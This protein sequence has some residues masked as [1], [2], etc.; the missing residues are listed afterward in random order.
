ML[1]PVA[2]SALSIHPTPA[3]PGQPGTHTRAPSPPPAPPPGAP[4]GQMP[5]SGGGGGASPR[6]LP[7][8]S[9]VDLAV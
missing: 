8:G 5:P 9:V 3:V 1:S 2:L 6:P 4:S 7:R